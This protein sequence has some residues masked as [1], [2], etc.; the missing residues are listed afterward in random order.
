[1]QRFEKYSNSRTNKIGYVGA[2]AVLIFYFTVTSGY[3]L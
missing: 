1:M 2:D 3:A